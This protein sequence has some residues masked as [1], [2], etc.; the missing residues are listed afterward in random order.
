MYFSIKWPKISH[1][2]FQWMLLLNL[3]CLQ[4]DENEVKF[5]CFSLSFHTCEFTFTS[6]MLQTNG[7]ESHTS[8]VMPVT[9]LLVEGSALPGHCWLPK[10]LGGLARGILWS[11]TPALT[12][13]R[14]LSVT[15]FT[16]ALMRAKS[17]KVGTESKKKK[18]IDK[19]WRIYSVTLKTR[20]SL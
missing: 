7:I 4:G 9:L 14:A 18:I 5:V 2:S 15:N 16:S 20:L 3:S 12:P 17:L 1:K 10:R 6:L 11:A 19:S 13:P 8:T